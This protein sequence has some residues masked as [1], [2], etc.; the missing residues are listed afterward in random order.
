MKG[1]LGQGLL[2]H[3]T[4]NWNVRYLAPFRPIMCLC[5]YFIRLSTWSCLEIR[6][7]DEVTVWTWII[8]PLKE[9]KSSNIWEQI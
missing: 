2:R 6:M 7:Q 9:W 3:T 8:V 5:L 1:S 4:T